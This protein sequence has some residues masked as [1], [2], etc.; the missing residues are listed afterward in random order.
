MMEVL[1]QLITKATKECGD[2][3]QAQIVAANGTSG[4]DVVFCGDLYW[5]QGEHWVTACS[6]VCD[7]D[8]SRSILHPFPVLLVWLHPW[9][10]NT[11][12]TFS[13]YWYFRILYPCLVV[14]R[15]HVHVLGILQSMNFL[16]FFAITLLQVLQLAVR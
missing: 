7:D 14:Y 13:D 4:C 11:N 8:A 15:I 12:D 1:G 5:Q 10:T 2:A 16:F 6:H 3:N 9:G